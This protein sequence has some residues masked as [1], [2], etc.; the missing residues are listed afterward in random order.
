MAHVELSLSEALVPPARPAGG[1]VGPAGGYPGP[2]QPEDSLSRWAVAV[3][4]AAEP[5][6]L[7]DARSRIV[8]TSGAG[9]ELLGLAEPA[10]TDGRPLLETLQLIDFTAAP[11]AL[12]EADAVK[13]PPLLALSSGR[14]ARGLLRVGPAGADE[15]PDTLDA[16]T[17]PLLEGGEVVGSLTFLSAI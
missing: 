1:A 7:I 10:L 14:L 6:L 8:A 13:I 3:H 4:A 11:S 16:V 17:T 5:C 2:E 9:R 12:E 15:P